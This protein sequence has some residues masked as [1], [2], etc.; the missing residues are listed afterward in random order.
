MHHDHRHQAEGQA[1]HGPGAERLP[2]QQGS[3]AHAREEADDRLAAVAGG[4]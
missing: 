3:V 2:E 4:R 1:E